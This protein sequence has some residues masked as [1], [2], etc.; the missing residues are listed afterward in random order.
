MKS[1]STKPMLGT[2][3]LTPIV[4]AHR[5]HAGVIASTLYAAAGW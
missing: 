1:S 5:G 3:S 2:K 4:A